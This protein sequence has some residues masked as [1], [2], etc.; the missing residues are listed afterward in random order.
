MYLH[1]LSTHGMTNGVLVQPSFLGFDNS[2]MLSAVQSTGGQLRCIVVVRTDADM[3]SLRAMKTMGA[4]GVR[5]NLFNSPPPDF[6][7]DLWQGSIAKILELDW[8]IEI[9]AKAAH[10]AEIASPLLSRGCKLII[11]HF[12]GLD[13][14]LGVSDPG[15]AALLKLAPTDKMWIDVSGAYRNGAGAQGE[16]LSLQA[17]ALL[18]QA[19]GLEHLLWGSDWPHTEFEGVAT[20]DSVCSFLLKMVP[21]ARDRQVVLWEVPEKLFAFK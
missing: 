4:V 10:L 8:F 6:T 9:Y 12:G 11:D 1:N 15:F 18:K 7:D 2:Y 13:P 14:V 5:L 21:S 19:F 3:H 16:A 20:Y 17:F